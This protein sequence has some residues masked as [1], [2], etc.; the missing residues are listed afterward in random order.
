MYEA[1]RL[2]HFELEQL[3]IF[4]YSGSVSGKTTVVRYRRVRSVAEYVF[5]HI[6]S[7]DEASLFL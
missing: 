5:D 1:A 4:K 7:E 2:G 6:V 3:S